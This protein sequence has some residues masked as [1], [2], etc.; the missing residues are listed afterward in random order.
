MTADRGRPVTFD[1]PAQDEFL[2]LIADGTRVGDAADKLCISRRTPTQLAAR[3]RQFAD[4][5]ADAK[6]RGREARYAPERLTHG[7]VSTYN[8]HACRCRLCR[9]DATG[10]RSKY[11]ETTQPD[12]TAQIHPLP[13]TQHT[14]PTTKLLMLAEVS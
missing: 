13:I 10:A 1:G 12:A 2:R 7:T 14:T 9:A 8:N 11:R 4:R 6:T 5:L 3:N